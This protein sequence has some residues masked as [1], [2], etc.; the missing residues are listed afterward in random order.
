[1]KNKK[2]FRSYSSGRQV[3]ANESPSFD[4]S[5]SSDEQ[6]N[7][8]QIKKILSVRWRTGCRQPHYSNERQI[9]AQESAQFG[10]QAHRKLRQ[11]E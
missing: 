10:A 4:T 9:Q 3:S 6:A 8:K 5:V 7:W 2:Y 11:F 1:M